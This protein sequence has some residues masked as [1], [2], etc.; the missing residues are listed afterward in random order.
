MSFL[1]MDGLRRYTSKFLSKLNGFVPVT[2]KINGKALTSDITTHSAGD[3]VVIEGDTIGLVNPMRGVISQTQFNALPEEERKKGTYIISDPNEWSFGAEVSESVYSTEETVMGRWIDG[4]PLY[5]KVI[6]GVK[7]AT[8][9][10]EFKSIISLAYL[11]IDTL[12]QL[13]GSIVIDTGSK[14]VVPIMLGT[15][16]YIG[17]YL[18][19]NDALIETHMGSGF[20]DRDLIIILEYTKTTDEVQTAFSPSSVSEDAVHHDD[21]QNN[22]VQ[23]STSPDV[24]TIMSEG[25]KLTADIP[26]F[27]ATSE[28]EPTKL[29]VDISGVKFTSESE[30]TKLSVDISGVKFTSES[31]GTKFNTISV[32][33]YGNGAEDIDENREGFE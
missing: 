19:A 11:Q 33:G 12:V 30:P 23:V 1:D 22:T 7:T 13:H 15:S 20:H 2:R 10:E 4:K 18:A 14:Q 9:N 26:G 27:I 31:E 8:A 28:S 6:T 17:I 25:T 16:N 29:S 24:S 32:H 3:G 5:R 21:L